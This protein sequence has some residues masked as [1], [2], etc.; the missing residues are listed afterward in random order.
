MKKSTA[1]ADQWF[2]I[3]VKSLCSSEVWVDTIFVQNYLGNTFFNQLVIQRP[4]IHNVIQLHHKQPYTHCPA[5]TQFYA[6]WY[7]LHIHKILI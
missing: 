6:R 3:N 1:L 7:T 2:H 4:A 5:F